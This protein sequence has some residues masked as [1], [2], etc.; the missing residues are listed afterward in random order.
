M[1]LEK[2]EKWGLVISF[3][4]IAVVATIF[5]MLVMSAPSDRTFESNNGDDTRVIRP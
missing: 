3:T 1:A 5:P 2:R 4:I